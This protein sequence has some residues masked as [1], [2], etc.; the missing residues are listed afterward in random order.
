MR[1]ALDGIMGVDR[2]AKALKPIA[3]GVRRRL[4]GMGEGPVLV[5][6]SAKRFSQKRNNP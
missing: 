2:D 1:I 6:M 5:T 4:A 3:E